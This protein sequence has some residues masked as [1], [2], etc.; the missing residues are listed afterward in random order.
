MAEITISKNALNGNL[1]HYHVGDVRLLD[2]LIENQPGLGE[3]SVC[4]FLNG[5]L[6]ANSIHHDNMDERCD[7]KLGAFDHVQIAAAPQ[8]V[9][10]ISLAIFAVVAIGAAFLA[11]KLMPTPSIPGDLGAANTSPNNQLNAANNSF[12]PRQEAPNI[13]GQVVSYPDFIQ[14]SY[15]V[16]KNNRREF[17]E[18]FNIGVGHFQV[19]QVKDGA[20]L[21]SDLINSNYTIYEPGDVLEELYDVR[22]AE[23]SVDL[24]L[25]APDAPERT[26]TINS[27]SFFGNTFDLGVNGSAI[28]AEL[29]ITAG[30]TIH[31]DVTYV[32]ANTNTGQSFSESRNVVSVDGGVVEV[33]PNINVVAEPYTVDGEV[34][35]TGGTSVN[36]WF[37]LDGDNITTVRAHI[38]MPRGIR[39]EDGSS[40]T[41]SYWIQAERLDAATGNPTGEVSSI[42]GSFSG[43]DQEPRF[44]TRDL[45]VTA[46]RYR[47][48]VMRTS[49]LLPGNSADLL[50]L[51]RLESV[52]RYSPLV[53]T[54]ATGI[55]TN[56][57]SWQGFTAA[58]LE[59]AAI[60]VG[61]R[62]RL[63]A[64]TQNIVEVREVISI[65][66][67]SANN[68]RLN[69]NAATGG[70]NSSGNSVTIVNTRVN[71][72]AFGDFTILRTTRM[73]Q[74]LQGRGASEKV[75]ALVTRKLELFNPATGAFDEGNFT[76][77]RSFAQYVMYLLCRLGKVPV[78]L[79][80][81]QTLFAIESS[82]PA[83]LRHFDFTF[84]DKNIS[85][86]ERIT[87]ACNVARV[88]HF[89]I[90]NYWTFAREELQ[91]VRAALFNRRNMAPRGFVQQ[92]EFNRAAEY[93]SI[94]LEYVDP[95]KNAPAY[96]RR[97]IMSDGSIQN[98]LGD[99]VWEM[100]LGGCRSAAQAENRCEYEI[101][102]LA[103]Q[104]RTATLL[105]LSDGLN[106]GPG[107]RVA[108]ADPN[109]SEVFHGEVLRQVGSRLYL[110][111]KFEPAPGK[112]YYIYVTGAEGEVSNSVVATA[113]AG[114][115][116][117]VDAPGL[118][119]FHA[120]GYEVQLGSTY[121]IATSED[122]KASDWVV[123]SR[124]TIDN[125]GQVPIELVEYIPEVYP[126][127][128][129][130]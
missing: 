111:E 29:G 12:R 99:R 64:W 3:H 19:T 91:P 93:D 104:R 44:V 50:Q 30:S 7:I 71:R 123:I 54:Q 56:Q 11:V 115:P 37:T 38:A 16:Y 55:T 53:S 52:S 102:K 94:E 70:D 39:R 33:S 84:D 40:G 85:L 126:E 13:A 2:W 81:Y 62:L 57:M 63:I 130:E 4:V 65:T 17:T 129:G 98:G 42:S 103:K 36:P 121:V 106:V 27:G 89:Q 105:A 75:N 60:R 124:G 10:P 24:V 72:L 101:R 22:S 74:A 6:I 68:Y 49:N 1:S 79:V 14:R 5:T 119:T 31:I 80:D 116:F 107:Q 128:T 51:E 110:S 28:A 47:A 48:R 25:T 125:R 96:I 34:R 109:D 82:L 18:L 73:T 35:L 114:D 86:R 9:D 100:S 43:S 108:V 127:F 112:T 15:Y 78:N 59:A 61:S 118:T 45:E 95:V 20:T 46:G 83:A 26:A 120:D 41:V 113:V 8:G 88:R 32:D 122:E 117:A 58:H 67:L 77:T 90:G 23:G 69:F 21:F 76:A 87:A 92:I 66:Q 97:R